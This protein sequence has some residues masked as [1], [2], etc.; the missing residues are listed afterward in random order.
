M[1]NFKTTLIKPQSELARNMMK[2]P[3]ILNLTS[4]KENYIEIELENAMV[5]KIKTVL[6]ELGNGFSFIGNQYKI[7]IANKE[8]FI[9]H[10]I[11]TIF[12]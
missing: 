9:D 1:N 3:Y 4:L 10:K 8:Y 2:A 11:T 12:S 6:L 5:E 7:E